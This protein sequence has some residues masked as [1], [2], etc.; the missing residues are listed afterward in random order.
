MD[1][2]VVVAM[3][4]DEVVLVA[5]VVAHEDVLAMHRPVVPPPALCLFDGLAFRV[6]VAGEGNVVL[7]EVI[8]HYILSFCCHTV[9][10]SDNYVAKVQQIIKKEER[11]EKNYEL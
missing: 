3:E 7:L 10:N 9:V 5:L 2:E 1:V 8:E 11:R 4:T 6:I